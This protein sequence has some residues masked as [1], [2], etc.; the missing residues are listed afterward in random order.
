MSN[1]RIFCIGALA[2]AFFHAL[3][4]PAGWLSQVA[5]ADYWGC[6][7]SLMALFGSLAVVWFGD[8]K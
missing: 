1:A 5:E 2:G 7:M 3:A 4:S 8:R 6:R